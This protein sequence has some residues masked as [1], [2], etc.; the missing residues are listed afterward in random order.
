VKV[1]NGYFPGRSRSNDSSVLI[2]VHL[3]KTAGISFGSALDRHFDGNLL[4]DYADRPL[5]VGTFQRNC[6]TLNRSVKN[7]TAGQK[8]AHLGC[9][10]GHFM[11]L[12]YRFLPVAQEKQFVVWLRDPVERIASHYRYWLRD[13]ESTKSGP[14][15]RRVVDEGWSLER[16]CLG[17]ELQNVY[18]KFFWGFPFSRFSF[19]GITEC[20][21]Q[22]LEY[23]GRHVLGETLANS[24]D[25]AN[26]SKESQSY[27][28][29]ASLRTKIENHHAVDMSLYRK[30]VALRNARRS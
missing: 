26:P 1:S 5:N 23:F 12:K 30:A 24:V 7:I 20:Y 14:L 25:N 6:I 9:I 2:S 15:R 18:S 22:D 11:P 28:E 4:R 3:P 10:H 8:L 19:V 13:Y 27:I 16:F 29:D 21:E 17:P